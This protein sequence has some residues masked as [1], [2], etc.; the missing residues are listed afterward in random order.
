MLDV[1]SL[2]WW[3][4]HIENQCTY[5]LEY[6][7]L[8]DYLYAPLFDLDVRY[9][10]DIFIKSVKVNPTWWY[11]VFLNFFAGLKLIEENISKAYPWS[12]E[13]NLA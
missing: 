9:A 7:D 3:I 13:E 10:G 8:Y 1:D 6:I 12:D 2:G 5:Y 11:W 4:F